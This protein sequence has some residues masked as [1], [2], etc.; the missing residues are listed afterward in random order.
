MSKKNR[1]AEV[2][3]LGSGDVY[4]E[5]YNADSGMPS[6]DTVCVENKLLGRISGGATLEYTGTWYTAKDDTGKVE[7]TLIT[8]EEVTFKTGIITW[9]G[10]TLNVLCATGRVS[11]ANG[12]RTVKIGGIGNDNRKSYVIVFHHTDKIDGDLWIMI[13]GTNQSAIS[14]AFTKDSETTIDAEFT[15]MAQD[16][17]GTLITYIEDMTESK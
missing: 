8:E 12:K 1:D 15:A 5:E 16:S 2:I 13:R 4:Y 17:D 11:E 10:K 14:L 7:K 9:N 6:V 3:T